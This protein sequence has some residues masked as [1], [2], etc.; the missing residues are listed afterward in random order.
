MA[1]FS[2]LYS[3]KEA[4]AK[5]QESLFRRVDFL[6]SIS[7]NT[8]CQCGDIIDNI[9]ARLHQASVMAGREYLAEHALSLESPGK[10]A[11]APLATPLHFLVGLAQDS[12]YS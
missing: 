4:R 2:P 9:K 11:L 8:A 6:F 7:Q 12:L 3:S 5:V 1:A 10:L